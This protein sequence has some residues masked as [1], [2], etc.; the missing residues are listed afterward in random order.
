MKPKSIPAD[1]QRIEAERNMSSAQKAE[2]LLTASREDLQEA[3]KH[4]RNLEFNH[5]GYLAQAA[6]AQALQSIAFLLFDQRERKK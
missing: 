3:E 1:A 2:M 6:Q 4:Y 5:A